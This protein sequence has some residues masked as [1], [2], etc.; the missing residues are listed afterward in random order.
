MTSYRK[1]GELRITPKEERLL[2]QIAPIECVDQTLKKNPDGLKDQYLID[3]VQDELREVLQSFLNGGLSMAGYAA[4]PFMQQVS[5]EIKEKLSRISSVASILQH[6]GEKISP[7]R[8]PQSI[9]G[10]ASAFSSLYQGFAAVQA[11]GA[12]ATK[13]KQ[14]EQFDLKEYDK[15]DL[16]FLSPLQ[17]IQKI[18]RIIENDVEG[19]YLHGSLATN[20][21]VKGWS[22]CDTLCIVS[23]DTLK[24]PK[25]LLSLRSQLIKVRSLCYRIDP[26]QHHGTTIVSEYDLD[27]YPQTY[28]PLPLFDYTKSFGKDAI[29]EMR[30][31]QHSTFSYAKLFWFVSCFRRMHEEKNRSLNAYET[32]NLLHLIALF[33]SLYLQAKDVFV[34]KKFSF[35]VPKKD[36]SRELWQPIE[37]MTR[38]RSRWKQLPIYPGIRGYAKL[39][40]FVAYQMNA[41]L[42]DAARTVKKLD[43][44]T[45]KLIENMH[46]LSEEAWGKAVRRL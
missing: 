46:L 26:L 4:Y 22:D 41:R 44:D 19:L 37:E 5:S 14:C 13:K 36:F 20:D 28:F 9:T 33:P 7:V 23:A 32:K 10:C 11:K 16:G 15:E 8:V 29:G 38:I 21:F 24:S 35:N 42:I 30:L 25:R 2:S 27:S 31:R 45:E 34:Y 1:A 43:I 39:N 6:R 3:F 40:P 18:S 12:K 17:D